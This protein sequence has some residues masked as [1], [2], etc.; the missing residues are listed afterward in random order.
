MEHNSEIWRIMESIQ[1]TKPVFDSPDGRK[2]GADK[3]EELSEKELLSN[4]TGNVFC[5]F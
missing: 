2:V 1:E 4:K 5:N 3:L